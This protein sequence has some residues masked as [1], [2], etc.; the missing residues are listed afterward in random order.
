MEREFGEPLVD[1]AEVFR[2]RVGAGIGEEVKAGAILG[3]AFEVLAPEVVVV[4]E[5]GFGSEGGAVL[6][7]QEAL[8]FEDVLVFS[9][10]EAEIEMAAFE[11]ALDVVGVFFGGAEVARDEVVL[12]GD[13]E[14]GGTGVALA[15]GAAAELVIDAAGFVPADAEDAEATAF[16]GTGAEDDIDSAAGHVGGEG[17][18]T[19]FSGAGDDGG[20]FGFVLG[21]E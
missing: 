1:G 8:G 9:E 4:K 19:D 21:V 20:F 13:E 7:V 6:G 2:E 15:A 3:D 18:A 12:I 14:A 16:G 10:A 17:D 5:G 11:H